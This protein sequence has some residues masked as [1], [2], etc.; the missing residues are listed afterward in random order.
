MVRIII[1]A[2]DYS[3]DYEVMVPY[4]ALLMLGFIVDVACP[5]KKKG[6]FIRT[7]I[8]EFEG[9]Q[10]YSEKPGHLF[11]LNASFGVIE[12]EQYDGLYLAGGRA[13]EYLRLNGAVL[14]LARHFMTKKKPIAAICHGAQILTAADVVRGRRLTAYAAVEP[15]VRMAGGEFIKVEP[16][17]SVVDGN[18]VT[19]PAWHGHPAMLRDF[20]SLLVRETST[21]G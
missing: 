4:Q 10:T 17:A 5:G 20:V 2:G 16:E 13:C 1:I 8:H 14:D 12:A 18:L 7:A 9:E 21:E 11:R 15:E 3:E 6:E 19:A